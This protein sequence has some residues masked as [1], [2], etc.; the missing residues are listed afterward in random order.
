[1]GS[2]ENLI[3]MKALVDK[4]TEKYGRLPTEVDP[5]YLEMLRMSKYR[6]LNVPDFKPGKCANCGASKDDGRKYIDFGLE[7]D[8]YG[9]VYLCG[10]CLTDISNEMGLFDRLKA[11]LLETKLGNAEI[12]NLQAKGVELH[13]TVVRTFRSLEDFYAS[14]HSL[15][16]NSSL[17]PPPGA[18]PME[19][20][21]E[22]GTDK[23]ESGTKKTSSRTSKSTT[24]TGRQNVRSLTD[25][26]NDAGGNYSG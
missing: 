1:M 20:T 11:E 23:T 4:F 26:L 7:I 13:E 22:S 17:S 9:T 3:R 14:I 15:G 5:D 2:V 25:L 8:W 16:D 19:T 12:A 10:E 24:S 6:I 21:S 18:V